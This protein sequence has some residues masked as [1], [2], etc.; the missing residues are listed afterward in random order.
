MVLNIT[1]FAHVCAT[2][3]GAF[4]SRTFRRKNFFKTEYTPNGFKT[5][6]YYTIYDLVYM[7]GHGHPC[8]QVYRPMTKEERRDKFTR[9]YCDDRRGRRSPSSYWRRWEKKR[10]DTFND[11][12]QRMTIK[13]PEYDA[14]FENNHHHS[15]LWDWW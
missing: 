10:M 15:A 2:T 3:N 13:D 1:T 5:A 8:L 6:G 11:R 7:R 9:A 14:V 12:Q 4:V